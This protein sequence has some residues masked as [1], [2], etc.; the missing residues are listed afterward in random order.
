MGGSG[1][2]GLPLGRGFLGAGTGIGSGDSIGLGV[3]VGI[4]VGA[5]GGSGLVKPGEVI[6]WAISVAGGCTN[7]GTGVA[8]DRKLMEIVAAIGTKNNPK[9]VTIRLENK[10][11]LGIIIGV[12]S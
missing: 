6:L 3:A 12:D 11:I 2:V 4:V 1:A 9:S 5:G 10:L 8:T 7:V